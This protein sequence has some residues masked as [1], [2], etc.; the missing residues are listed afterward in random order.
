[1]SDSA[2]PRIGA[3]D[4]L[5]GLAAFAVLSEH[6]LGSMGEFGAPI[7]SWLKFTPL[8]LLFMEGRGAVIL[9][10]VLSGY[11]LALPFLRGEGPSYPQFLAKRF[12]RIYLP[13]VAAMLLSLGLSV[14]L[15]PRPIPGLG[16]AFNKVWSET[17]NLDLILS[18]LAMLG[19]PRSVS[20]VP[21]GWTLV[22]ELRISLIIPL[23][24][25]CV[26]RTSVGVMLAAVF[27]FWM[28][29]RAGRYFGLGY[30]ECGN[31]FLD[32]F[33]ITGYFVLFFVLGILGAKHSGHIASFV[34]AV[35]R[36]AL[37][38]V[39]VAIFWGFI[40]HSDI[41]KGASA[42]ALIGFANRIG[43]PLVQPALI[44]LGR[45][46]YSLYIVHALI[47]VVVV[48]VLYPSVP[49][50]LAVG[51]VIP[52]SLCAAALFHYWVEAPSLALSRRIGESARSA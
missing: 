3:L 42:I 35:P 31:N 44:W 15:A 39:A 52:V 23:L 1:M 12:C 26:R 47:Q 27:L 34:A 37:L 25:W 30:F 29:H 18:N 22:Y 13:Y 17:P 40:A 43:R 9:F 32:S 28:C 38:F 14:F 10:F 46:S 5:R 4:S 48:H 2:H 16:I 24:V 51:S 36:R 20:F 50:L 11:V 21:P 41:A 8:R 33:I 6:C 45:I 7:T 49:L 19:T